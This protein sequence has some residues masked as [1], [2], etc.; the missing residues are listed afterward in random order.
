MAN[1]RFNIRWSIAEQRRRW[2]VK[3]NA[4]AQWNRIQLDYNTPNN[5]SEV[6]VVD[7]LQSINNVFEEII[8]H[9]TQ[10]YSPTDQIR[11]SINNEALSHEINIPFREVRHL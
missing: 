8:T 10:Q 6:D 4:D 2:S 1:S 11:V 7:I 3:F 5:A 9:L